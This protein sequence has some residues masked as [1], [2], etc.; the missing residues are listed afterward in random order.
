MK[1]NQ[2]MNKVHITLIGGQAMPVYIGIKE[3]DASLFVLIHSSR[4]EAIADIIEKDIKEEKPQVSTRKILMDSSDIVK[5]KSGMTEVLN[6]YNDCLIEANITGGTK[7][8]SIALTMQASE[9]R[10]VT[11]F[12]IDQ[13]CKIFNY[14]DLTEKTID[15][16]EGGISQI[17]KY[18]LNQS[19][20]HNDFESYTQEDYELL[21]KIKAVRKKYPRIFNELTIPNKTNKNRF[22]NNLVDHLYDSSRCSEIYW[23]RRKGKSQEVRMLYMD[24]FGEEEEVTL[25][26]PHAFD[27]VTSSGWFEYE[28][29]A[30]FKSWPKCKEIWM[31]VKFPYKNNNPKNEIDIIVNTGNKL[32]FIECKTQIFDNTD[33]D[34]FASAVK[35]YGGMGTKALFITREPMSDLAIEKCNTNGVMEYSVLNERH[36]PNGKKMLFEI[37][38]DSLFDSNTK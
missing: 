38:N 32:L 31:N 7:P 11:L 34:K 17:L 2:I 25:A 20:S 26:S 27:L 37:L 6:S 35:N 5:I 36:C 9:R 8:W 19:Q 16:I 18:N 22:S 24:K 28:V 30:M 1:Y 3:S 33:I 13:N 4:T 23:D 21:D 12:Y 15:N 29:A 14:N 10:N